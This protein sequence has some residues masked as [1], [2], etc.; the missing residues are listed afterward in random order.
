MKFEQLVVLLPC[1]SLEDLSLNREAAEAEE[2]LSAWSALYHPVLVGAA[3]NTPQWFQAGGPPPD[4]TDKLI[5]LPDCC[6]SQLPPDWLSEAEAAGAAVVR[7]KNREQMVAAALAYLDEIPPVEPQ[8]AADFLA[9]GV[10]HL[11]VELLTRQLR[12]MSNLDEGQFRQ[13]TLTAAEQALTGDNE[14]ARDSLRSAYDLL[15]ESREY[16]YPVEAHLLD[17]TLVAP[18]TLGVSLRSELSK[19]RPTNLLISGKTLAEMATAEPETLTLLQDG[20]QKQTAVIIGGEWDEQ[21]LPL[22]PLEAILAQLRRGLASYETHLGCR[23]TIFGR[24]RFGLTPALPHLLHKLGFVGALHFTLED[25]RFPSGNQSKIRWEGVDGTPLEA[26]ARLPIDATQADAF[27]RLPETLGQTMDLDHA[28]TVVFAHWPGQSSV[29]YEDVRR[30]ADYSSALG[31]IES[32]TDYFHSTEYSGQTARHSAD[33]YRSPYL[34]QDVAAGRRNPISRWVSYYSR[35]ALVEAAATLETLAQLVTSRRQREGQLRDRLFQEIEDARVGTESA[36]GD[37]DWRLH[38]F[39]ETAKKSL[40]EALAR[41]NAESQN[42]CLVLNP[43]SFSQRRAVDVS[44]LKHPPAQ[45][46]A[47]WM[48]GQADATKTAIVDLPAMGFAWLEAGPEPPPPPPVPAR[49]KRGQKQEETPPLA[50]G[51]ILR[52]DFFQVEL[53]PVTG[54]IKSIRDFVRRENRLAQQI[55]FRSA[56]PMR[57]AQGGRGDDE[58]AHYTVMAADEIRVVSPGP[59]VGQIVSRGRLLDLEGQIVARFVQ[60]LRLE[61]GSRVL[62]LDLEL[63]PIREPEADPWNSYYGLRFAWGSDTMD[64]YR[65]VHLGSVSSGIA[66]VEAPQFIDLREEKIRTT[67]LT[68]GLPYHRRFGLRR[69]DTLVIVRGESARRFRMGIGVDLPYPVPAALGL[70]TP[71]VVL[72]EVPSPLAPSGWLFHVS[73]KNVVAT[74][75]EPV[76]SEDRATG[77]RVRLLETEGRRTQ[78]VLRAL[79]PVKTARKTDFASPSPVELP[80]ADDQVTIEI[81]PHEW[82]EVEVSF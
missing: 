66:Q 50:E 53:H 46:G 8:L 17:L 55:A 4:L 65:S 44:E 70:L 43:W 21:E 42:G 15:T 77:V 6:E 9:L 68:G 45:G 60:T 80:V 61:R 28:A 81:G 63:D 57:T 72:R 32:M 13:R 69:L 12:Y 33:Q 16:F 67:I 76:V 56:R 25:G 11:L 3:G 51:N 20:L 64:L 26:L 79:R 1:S 37:L 38:A 27:F 73:A 34:R 41:P 39:L 58:E 78:A 71:E 54:T 24:R 19:P 29:W 31:R 30:M 52:N 36:E 82:A 49:K 2:L 22:L 47:V 7:G 10:C 75:W 14:A 48:A 62:E 74:A 40:S 18:T 5:I 59:L 23:P 35:R